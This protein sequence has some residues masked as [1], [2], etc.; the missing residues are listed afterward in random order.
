MDHKDASGD[1]EKNCNAAQKPSNGLMS[2]HLAIKIIK[3]SLGVDCLEKI[4]NLEKEYS[5][6]RIARRPEYYGGES[7]WGGP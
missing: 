2:Y 4:S 1:R 5:H 7:Q 6:V 3:L